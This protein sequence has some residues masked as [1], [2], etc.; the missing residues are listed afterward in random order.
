MARKK[1]G[2]IL[3]E[4]DLISQDD[5]DQALEK[6]KNS[7]KPLGKILEEMDVVLEE[8][9]AKALATQFT[10]PY[11]SK[12]S[13]FNFPLQLLDHISSDEALA[14]LIFPLKI[15]GKT[16]Y[17]AMANPLDMALQSD[18]SFKLG[19][20]IFPCVATPYEI[21]Q[22]IKKH[23]L[24]D[25]QAENK[26]ADWNILLV[27]SH[28]ITLK[29]AE[30][31]LIKEGYSINKATNGAEGLK[32][33]TQIL[34]NLIITEIPMP[35]MDGVALFQTL[36]ENQETAAIPFIAL[37]SQNTPE[38]EYKLLDMGFFDVLPKPLNP[39]RLVARVKLARRYHERG[40]SRTG[41]QASQ[42]AYL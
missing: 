9:I 21:K 5:L 30:A 34:P 25:I 24:A 31:A 33:A 2:E 26:Q 7:D 41:N 38:D 28:D 35:R 12:F 19:L 42:F 17:L 18:L 6:Q 22:A 15:K 16:L 37:T 39:L 14:K 11:I 3:R 32:I 10:F 40:R 8:D 4:N 36:K 27:D 29:A 13:H 23:Y 1:M 20:K